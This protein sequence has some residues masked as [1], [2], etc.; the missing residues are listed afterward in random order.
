VSGAFNVA[1]TT[2]VPRTS[3]DPATAVGKP[4]LDVLTV[5]YDGTSCKGGEL[6]DFT[7]KMGVRNWT[8]PTLAYS[9][10]PT[11]NASGERVYGVPTIY[12]RAVNAYFGNRP[13]QHRTN[14]T[15]AGAV[16]GVSATDSRPML[17]PITKTQVGDFSNDNGVYDSKKSEL[18]G[19]DGALWGDTYM[20]GYYGRAFDPT[21][22]V[23][24]PGMSLSAMDVTNDGCV[25]LPFVTDPSGVDLLGG[26]LDVRCAATGP[27]ARYPQATKQQVLRFLVTHELGHATGI[28]SHTTLSGDVMY[29]Y[30][31]NWV[32]D[33]NF[34]ATAAGMITITNGGRP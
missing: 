6:C 1:G 22:K 34:S 21:T 13:Y 17:A 9:S 29:Q 32:R 7:G 23:T 18:L 16:A 5:I 15:S 28:T 14:R 12:K 26:K 19:T 25:E 11:T 8:F 10:F 33:L 20:P 3:F 30:S 4:L 24:P 2:S 31:I 27:Q